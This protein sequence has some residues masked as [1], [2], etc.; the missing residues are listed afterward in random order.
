MFHLKAA[1]GRA[2]SLTMEFHRKV[3]EQLNCIL[4]RSAQEAGGSKTRW[5]L[6]PHCATFSGYATFSQL[7]LRF[8]ASVSMPLSTELGKDAM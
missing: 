4:F 2:M 7:F 5:F 1:S 8:G 6:S 3:A